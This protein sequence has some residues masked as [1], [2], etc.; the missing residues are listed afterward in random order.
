MLTKADSSSDSH[1]T[2]NGGGS[3]DLDEYRAFVTG[4]LLASSRML[5]LCH[6]N[7]SAEQATETRPRRPTRP[8]HGP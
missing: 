1:P 7:A 4:E 5:A 2:A 3:L 6:G 8:R